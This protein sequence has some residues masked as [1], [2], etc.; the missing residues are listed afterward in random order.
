M[1][2]DYGIYPVILLN[3]RSI[4]PPIQKQ[5]VSFILRYNPELHNKRSASTPTQSETSYS[6]K[7]QQGLYL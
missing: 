7:Q 1:G 6:E 5:G 4:Y 3:E 2:G